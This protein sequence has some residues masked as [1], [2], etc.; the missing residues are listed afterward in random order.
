MSDDHPDSAEIHRIVLRRIKI[1]WLQN[2]GGEVDRVQLRIVVGVDR[3]RSH[4]PLHA[5][6]RLA[7][8]R[9]PALE[10]KGR[11][12]RHV[13]RIARARDVH[14]RVVTPVRGISNLVFD[15]LQLRDGLLLGGGRHPAK[16]LNVFTQ[17]FFD[18]VHH[19]D[20]AGLTLWWEGTI[21]VGLAKCFAEIAVRGA[22]TA[23]PARLLL[24]CPGQTVGEEVEVFVDHSL[25]HVRRRFVNDLPAQ[26]GFPM[27][28]RMLLQQFLF[29]AEEIR[30]RQNVVVAGRSLHCLQV[31][32]PINRWR[33]F[34]H[35][36]Q[37]HLVVNVLGIAALDV[38]HL[39]LRD[40]GFEFDH[41][42]GVGSGLR[43]RFARKGEH[44]LQVCT[45]LLEDLG[46]LLVCF[47]IVIAI[48]QA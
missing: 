13:V 47:Q 34:T 11:G 2:T 24:F 46:R 16:A 15:P 48:G 38:V 5:I 10:L 19:L 28:E 25:V 7:N 36:G 29:R 6:D 17:C 35:L 43:R 41:R 30:R 31:R 12:L 4:G 1:R 40:F 18:G 33:K 27:I 3:R 44:L 14:T 39:R 9:Y 42:A 21:D 26:I 22:H 8:L 37:A 32:I 20:G 23:A 45:I